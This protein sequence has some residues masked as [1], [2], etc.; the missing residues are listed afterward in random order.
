MD[1]GRLLYSLFQCSDKLKWNLRILLDEIN[2]ASPETLEC[3]SSVLQGP[4]ASIV[5]TEQGSFTPIHRHPDFRLFA[6]M[7]PATDVGKKD[8]PTN[9]RSRF[10][11]IYMSSP[12][13]DRETLLTIIQQYIGHCSLADKSAPL[14]VA[15]FYFEVKKLADKRE[16]ADG[17]NHRPH[18]SLRTLARALVF[19]SDMVLSFGL[20][21]ALWEGCLMAFSMA[22]NE[23]SMTLVKHLAKKYLLAGVKNVP[24]MMMQIP[25]VPGGDS[26][27]NFERI[28]PFWL[29]RGMLP[30]DPASE[31]ILT[32][33]VQAKLIDLARVIVTRRFPVLIE[34]PTSSGKTSAIEYLA[35][36]T[37]HRFVRVNNH[38]HTDIQE[39][40][41][42]YVSDPHTGKL[43]FHDGILVR[44]L[45]AGD[46]IVLDELNLAP[47]DVLEALNRLLDDNRE[48]VIPETRE[49]VRPHPHFM[50][51]ATQNPPGLYAGRKILSRAFRNRFLEI[52]FDDVPQSEL[53]TILS[54]RCRIPDSYA[55]RIVRVFQEL[56]KRRQAGRVFESKHGF[57]TLRDLFRWAGREAS[58]TL[59]LAQNGYMLLA[60][61]ARRPDDK[62]I[63]KDVIETVMKERID[64]TTLYQIQGDARTF[65]NFGIAVPASSNV[66]W[67]SAMRRLFVLVANALKHNE[68]VL[69]VGDTGSGKTTVCQLYADACHKDLITLNCHQSTETADL[70]GSQRPLRN[71]LSSQAELIHQAVETLQGLPELTPVD[72]NPD[73][74]GILTLLNRALK[75]PTLPPGTMASLRSHLLS[76][77]QSK[78]LFEWHDG[79]LVRAM[80]TGYTFLL[81]EISLADDSVLERLN[82][83]L[84]PA[85]NIVLAE[86]GGFDVDYAQVTAHPD[87]KLLAT[88]N[89]GGDYGKKELSPALRNRFTEIWVPQ[90]ELKS[91][92]RMIIHKSWRHEGLLIYTGAILTFTGWL[93]SA[94]GIISAASL[95]DILVSCQ[96]SS[97]SGYIRL[98]NN[99]RLGL[100]LQMRCLI[101]ILHSRQ[102]WYS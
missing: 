47:T 41:G 3:I 75:L 102:A 92:L 79:P 13:A 64:T 62:E 1:I 65:T 40:L 93:A 43:V 26:P 31:Y 82:S 39:Y 6:C 50:L 78:A 68:P 57:A 21:R 20:R 98:I 94:V 15:E 45:R 38:E 12:D 23:T 34:G 61:R 97:I 42:T 49:V 2:L 66:I 24:A 17:S 53:Q 7:N 99:N 83:V 11:E 100:S 72:V 60:E 87:F 90:V 88:M 55:S 91:D 80:R 51:F 59:Q 22:L 25:L 44:A 63:V 70:I 37:G 19:T 95:R 29:Q 8:L 81:D 85:R 9:I 77:Q 73:V 30:P 76:L 27:E 18:F 69:L 84:E 89:P 32:P 28:G 10:T 36:R 74:D 4:T 86:R 71:R 67:T 101:L 5:L 14:D 46:W 48:L 96:V 56:S 16:L 35:R 52:Y 33:S 54:E 58:S